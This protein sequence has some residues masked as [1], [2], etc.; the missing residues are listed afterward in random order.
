MI[1][2]AATNGAVVLWNLE[3]EGLRNA[4]GQSISCLFL[5]IF[6]CLSIERIFNDHQR[7]VNRICWHPSD[8]NLLLSASQDGTVR[9]WVSLASCALLFLNKLQDKRSKNT[10]TYRPKSES[11]RDAR[12]NPFQ[13]SKFALAFENGTVQTW[14]IRKPISPEL[15]FTAHKGLVLAIDWHPTRPNI[16]ATGS[17]DRSIKIWDLKN[18]KH[19]TQTIQTIANVGRIQ[20]R[21]NVSSQIASCASLLD[22]SIYLWDVHYP[23][24]PLACLRAHTGIVTGFE[25]MDTPVGVTKDSGS[26]DS[27]LNSSMDEGQYD[28]WQHI[29]SCSKDGTLKLHSLASAYKPYEHIRTSTIGLTATGA[30]AMSYD[31]VDRSGD[32]LQLFGHYDATQPLFNTVPIIRHNAQ[33]SG[34]RHKLINVGMFSQNPTLSQSFGFDSVTFRNLALNYKLYGESFEDLCDFNASIAEKFQQID[35]RQTWRIL[36]LLFQSPG[37]RENRKSV[38]VESMPQDPLSPV[39]HQTSLLEQLDD[40]NPSA[41]QGFEMAR[42]TETHASVSKEAI[43][44]FEKVDVINKVRLAAIRDVIDYYTELGNVQMTVS[45]LIVL[46]KVIKDDAI[47]SKEFIQK[48]YMYYID[49]LHQAQLYTVATMLIKRCTDTSIS[50]INMKA[51]T[52]SINC[53]QCSKPLDHSDKG[54]C[55]NC[56]VKPTTCALCQL[57]TKGLFVWCPSCSHGGH[58]DCMKRWFKNHTVCP[59]GC[60]HKCSI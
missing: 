46:E 6:T 14:D 54:V 20:W 40:I 51:T 30:V 34:K 25:W 58:L 11:I 47:V 1:A 48:I 41:I 53:S 32:A 16:L 45:L 31:Q 29:I 33:S 38:D 5:S 23:C 4:Q 26:A 10:I 42:E 55:F 35:I 27:P 21:P 22:N 57:T 28:Y 60:L 8:V 19:P 13:Q 12:F 2:T 3:R 17:R 15:K 50:Q 9:L 43:K 7:A 24:I 44:R 52:I 49:L 56:R 18:V 36:K 59:T 39:H 37:P